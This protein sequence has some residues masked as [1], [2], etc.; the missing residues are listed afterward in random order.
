M[1]DHSVARAAADLAGAGFELPPGPVSL[2]GQLQPYGREP[3]LTRATPI[4]ATE[5]GVG[6]AERD[7][8]DRIGGL[9]HMNSGPG[10]G[11]CPDGP[12]RGR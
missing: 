10:H 6:S 5:G 7:S 12:R 2:G 11:S 3:L 1:T 8:L 9:M 4:A